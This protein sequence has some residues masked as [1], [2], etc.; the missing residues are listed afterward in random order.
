MG[1]SLREWQARMGAQWIR[2]ADRDI[3]AHYGDPASE[4]RA[5]REAAGLA[6]RSFRGK[7]RLLGKDRVEFLNGM[8]TNDVMHLAPG[9]G[10]YAALTTAKAKMLSDARIYCL[11]DSLLLDIEPEAVEK[12]KKHLDFYIISSDVTIEDL[13][14]SWGML[15]LFGPESPGILSKAVSVSGLPPAEL[16]FIKTRI[17]T[18]D[19]LIARNEMTGEDGFDIFAPK[20]VLAPM[21]RKLTDA[22]ARPIGQQAVETLRVEAGI[23]RYGVDMDES[24]FPMEAGLT[25]RAVS[26]TKGCYIGQETIARALA[27]GHMNRFLAGLA[28]EG[29]AV[30]ER[31]SEIRAGDRAVGSVTSAVFSPTLG[32]VIAIGIIHRDFSKPGTA[33]SVRSGGNPLTATVTKLPFYKR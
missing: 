31:G 19:L 20:E 18:A 12:V 7:L 33:V 29:T 4:H 9:R 22:G 1:D 8:V 13:T 30:P 21:F 5:V 23:P 28:I 6:D 10:C 15:S 16:D 11:E 3:P 14:E 26:E 24:H 2:R 25:E 27:Q 32:R 17:E